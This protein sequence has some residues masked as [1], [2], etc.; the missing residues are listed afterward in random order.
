MPYLMPGQVILACDNAEGAPVSIDLADVRRIKFDASKTA[1]LILRSG[2]EV[3]CSAKFVT[4]A[5]NNYGWPKGL[6]IEGQCDL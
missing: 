5:V 4:S 3:T 1:R 6:T 2:H